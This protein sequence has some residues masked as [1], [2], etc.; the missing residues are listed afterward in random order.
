VSAIPPTDL[1]WIQFDGMGDIS[2]TPPT[3]TTPGGAEVKVES[4]PDPQIPGTPGHTDGTPQSPSH[5][6]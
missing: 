2:V 3:I 4:V 5:E 6:N 1:V